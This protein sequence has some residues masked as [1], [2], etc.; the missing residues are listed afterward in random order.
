M[1]RLMI[2]E[3]AIKLKTL[4][5][6]ILLTSLLL[7]ILSC[8]NKKPTRLSADD[9]VRHY[10]LVRQILSKSTESVI[11]R[12]ITGNHRFTEEWEEKPGQLFN[13]GDQC[14]VQCS[15]NELSGGTT[16][17]IKTNS[18]I[19]M[20]A[21]DN[22]GRLSINVK[23][24]NIANDIIKSNTNYDLMDKNGELESDTKL[25]LSSVDLDADGYKEMVVTIGKP[26]TGI[27]MTSYIFTSDLNYV[28]KI[29][30]WDYMF[31]NKYH[32]II[33]PQA[34]LRWYDYYQYKNKKV[35]KLGEIDTDNSSQTGSDRVKDTQT[36]LR[37]IYSNTK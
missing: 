22:A 12:D 4:K 26:N 27:E 17:K 3:V 7:L 2:N 8:G 31:L 10:Q 1:E 20:L 14:F 11:I 24:R 23:S 35:V 28:G 6:V 18:G 34:A 16:I 13:I 25:Q 37:K 32:H 29:D 15:G 30:G 21:A 9:S 19:V 36:E 33:A 5:S